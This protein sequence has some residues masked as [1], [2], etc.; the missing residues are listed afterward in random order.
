[1][2]EPRVPVAAAGFWLVNVAGEVVVHPL[3]HRPRVG[4]RLES[5]ARRQLL[6]DRPLEDP[7]RRHQ[8]VVVSRQFDREIGRA[9]ATALV[10]KL[11]E[12]P[13]AALAVQRKRSPVGLVVRRNR[14]R[15][16]EAGCRH[17]VVCGHVHGAARRRTARRH[18]DAQGIHRP[19]DE[20]IV[21]LEVPLRPHRV[22]RLPED[23]R[24]PRHGHAGRTR[25]HVRRRDGEHL[26]V[27]RVGQFLALFGLVL[28]EIR[29]IGV[30][31]LALKPGGGDR[32]E[33]VVR[34]AT[35][36]RLQAVA[37]L[38]VERGDVR[39]AD[40]HDDVRNHVVFRLR[41]VVGEHELALRTVDRARLLVH[42]VT[43]RQKLRVRRIVVDAV[44]DV[45]DAM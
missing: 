8:L 23:F 9:A 22:F 37:D 2:V 13:A 33:L 7:W 5:D 27:V 15:H 16:L 6:A 11:D 29:R 31:G 3:R 20:I 38:G 10:R 24:F 18:D 1:M 39:R 14:R 42:V 35:A 28:I 45:G 25:R 21:V 44:N 30:V 12:N 4:A 36:G 32:I 43:H 17:H 34:I 26:A 40:L 41:V 19:A